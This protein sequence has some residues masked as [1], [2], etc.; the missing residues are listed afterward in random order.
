MTWVVPSALVSVKNGKAKVPFLN[1]NSKSVTVRRK[2]CL[3]FIDI[4]LEAQVAVV[5]SEQKQTC[6]PDER[7]CCA[8]VGTS[9]RI[10]N[11]E[12]VNVGANLS[13]HE[14]AMVLDLLEQ[15]SRCLPSETNKLDYADNVQHEIETGNAL[16]I[17]SRPFRIS[18]FERRI[19]ADK[20]N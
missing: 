3:I 16:P 6:Q 17:T 9:R 7:I 5:P 14:K 8:A 4:D 19:I 15:H 1:V 12:D 11:R 2:N 20:V 10:T 13:Q 18:Q